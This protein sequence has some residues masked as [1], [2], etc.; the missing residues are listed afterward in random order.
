MHKKKKELEQNRRGEKRRYMTF[1]V[2]M[3]LC[4]FAEFDEIELEYLQQ[5]YSF[6]VFC[7]SYCS[8]IL[9]L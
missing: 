7:D 9:I 1:C 5:L 2:P 4:L 6:L 3:L 8:L